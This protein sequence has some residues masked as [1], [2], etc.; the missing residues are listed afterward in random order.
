MK[1]IRT[2]TVGLGIALA[3]LLAAHAVG[4]LPVV[5]TSVETDD[6]DVRRR[7]ENALAAA[8]ERAN[9]EL[10]D[11]TFRLDGS[12]GAGAVQV[13]AVNSPSQRVII[14]AA[15]GPE[16]QQ[17][18]RNI[19]SP[20]DEMLESILAATLRY[21]RA[22]IRGFPSAG[23]GAPVFID[24]LRAAT[25]PSPSAQL[26]QAGLYPTGVTVR[27]NGNVVVAGTVFAVELDPLFRLRAYP[28][29]ELL[30]GGNL[31]Y[32]QNVASTPGG[33]LFFRPASGGEIYRLVDGAP[34]PQRIRAGT[35]GMGSFAA[36]RDGSVVAV[37][38]VNRR[39]IRVAERRPRPI[40]LYTSDSSFISALAAGPTGGV[41]AFD[42]VEGRISVFS[43]EGRPAETIIPQ[44]PPGDL[45][46]TVGIGT[47]ENGDF[48]LLSRTGLWKLARD[49][50][51][52]WHTPDI[53]DGQGSAFT[54]AMGLALD[55]QRGLIYV[56]DPGRRTVT[57]F[58]DGD[59]GALDGTQA[60]LAEASA[61]VAARV[62]AG[63]DAT[64]ALRAQAALYEEL[65][66]MASAEEA[67]RRILDVDPFDAAA[68]EALSRIELTRLENRAERLAAETRSTLAELGRESA[69]ASYSQALQAYE[70]I[71]ALD[72]GRADID[73]AIRRLR[74]DFEGA[75]VD[76]RRGPRT[77]RVA[78]LEVEDLFPSLSS[79]YRSRPV[80]F[81]ELEN[82]GDTTL[83]DLTAELE[84]RRFSDYPATSAPVAELP[85]GGRV[86]LPLRV[87]LNEQVFRIEEDLPV[88]VRVA[89]R[90][91]GDDGTVNVTR[92]TAVTLYRRTALTWDETEKLAAFVTP[93]EGNVLRFTHSM[94][95]SPAKGVGAGVE[96]FSSRLARAARIADGV[97]I[98]DVD[99]VP[100]PETPISTVLGREAV[101]DTVRFPR[102]TL[103]YGA[104]DCDD[105]TV[106]LGSLYEA[107]GIPAAIVTT[108]DH[109]LLAFDTGE[110]ASRR[111]LFEASGTTVFVHDDRVWLPVETTVLGR[112]FL[113]AWQAASQRIRRAGGTDAT[114]LVPL[115]SAWERYPSLSVPLTELNILPPAQEERRQRWRTTATDVET[116][117]Y[118]ATVSR[119]EHEVSAAGGQARL[120]ALNRLA[121]VHGRFARHDAAREAL[122][123]ALAIDPG[124]AAGRVNLANIAI[125]ERDY[126]EAR[127]LLLPVYERRP[128]SVLV[129]ALLARVERELGNPE[130][131]LEHAGL[132]QRRAPD[133]ARRYALLDT[134]T[135]TRA[136]GE[137]DSGK[138]IWPESPEDL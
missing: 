67:W 47:Y 50:S 13:T 130:R 72:P 65:E 22:G 42:S 127:R 108:P 54:Q 74:R 106:L 93:N 3:F 7:F 34:R 87:I 20:W 30:E 45:G 25:I 29:R 59:F 79:A 41:W 60:R 112:G 82:T 94:S 114:G 66:A 5:V 55:S 58:A 84:V 135:G 69:R 46:Q 119:L 24:E 85:P 17:I 16:G 83:R 43:R 26:A 18:A 134:D 11:S 133:L 128:E 99:Y 73:A 28:G 89:A 78:G 68:S 14:V 98:Y 96:T 51:L 111:W 113:G 52:L 27:P 19:F 80:G 110:P 76:P 39:A 8:I 97:G 117:V 115:S 131:A 86:R 91:E 129:N 40:E 123:Q 4:A 23:R 56:A 62:E 9:R 81:V 118:G 44:I 36:L 71:R 49:G 132:V 116:A 103:L 21:A 102:T 48:V 63:L 53:P 33:T 75:G 125:A 64:D 121:M 124:N 70:R 10:G 107:S 109:V 95:A 92:T 122:E 90:A 38:M 105:T 138:L 2:P 137:P 126:A 37:D 12:T 35:T 6:A 120:R 57:R 100:D 1:T 31:N 104:G 88:Q 136:S 15:T 101:V 32:A 77:L 61:D